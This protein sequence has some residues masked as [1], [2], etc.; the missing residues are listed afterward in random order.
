MA[1]KFGKMCMGSVL[2]EEN[3]FYVAS[4]RICYS[5][6]QWRRQ[7]FVMQGV[8]KKFGTKKFLNFLYCFFSRVQFL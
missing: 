2:N 8:F 5:L 7:E 1:Y 3:N 4:F 6:T